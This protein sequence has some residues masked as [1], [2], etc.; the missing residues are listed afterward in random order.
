MLTTEPNAVNTLVASAHL[1]KLRDLGLLE[2]KG[3]GNSTYYVPTLNLLAPDI[4]TQA[5]DIRA[6]APDIRTQARILRL[7]LRI[8]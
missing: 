6:Q 1:R 4:T 2:Q 7:E 8:L 5:P 3:R